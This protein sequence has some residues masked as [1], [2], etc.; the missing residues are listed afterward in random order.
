MAEL[1]QTTKQNII[2]HIKNICEEAALMLERTVKEYLTVGVGAF[3]KFKKIVLWYIF[4]I[5]TT[6]NVHKV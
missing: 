6:P 3:Q 1:F 4:G 2:L 5:K